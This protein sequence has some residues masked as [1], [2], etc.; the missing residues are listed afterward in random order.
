[1][2]I[3]YRLP[4]NDYYPEHFSLEMRWDLLLFLLLRIFNLMEDD[5]RA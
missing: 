1:M 4:W 3:A 5:A 2:D